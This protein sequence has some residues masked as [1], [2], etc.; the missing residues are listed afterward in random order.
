MYTPNKFLVIIYNLYVNIQY[1]F[2][3]SKYILKQ[4]TPDLDP[5]KLVYHLTIIFIPYQASLSK[6][7]VCFYLFLSNYFLGDIQ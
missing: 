3:A 1:Y 4:T 6:M 2:S 7:K 5:L